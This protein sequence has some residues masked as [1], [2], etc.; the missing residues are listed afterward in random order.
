MCNAYAA[1]KWTWLIINL[2][3]IMNNFTL[4]VNQLWLELPMYVIVEQV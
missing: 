1:Q 2:K 3:F 4:D